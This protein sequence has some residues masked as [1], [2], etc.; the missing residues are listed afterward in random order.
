MTFTNQDITPN[1]KKLIGIK[2]IFMIGLINSIR[3]AK[4]PPAVRMLIHPPLTTNAGMS[5]LMIQIETI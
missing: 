4:I 2:R 1:V 3:I 5:S